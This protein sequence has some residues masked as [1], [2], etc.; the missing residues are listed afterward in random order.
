MISAPAGALRTLDLEE[1][2]RPRKM[3]EAT[4][5]GLR[6]QKDIRRSRRYRATHRSHDSR[7]LRAVTE[8]R[9]AAGQIGT[10]D[11]APQ[12]AAG[13]LVR[14]GSRERVYQLVLD[15][16]PSPRTHSSDGDVF[17]AMA[18]RQAASRLVVAWFNPF[19][20]EAAFGMAAFIWTSA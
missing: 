8:K 13:Q 20:T 17:L 2:A 4:A 16:L 15:C 19:V 6:R 1:G 3:P 14:R 9:D 7:A 5:P 12:D 18:P 11:H 10:P